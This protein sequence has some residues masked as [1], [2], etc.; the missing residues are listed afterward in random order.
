MQICE[1]RKRYGNVWH[2]RSQ[3]DENG[4]RVYFTEANAAQRAE[5]PE[6]PATTLTNFF[7]TCQTDSF[8]RTLFYSEMPLFYTWNAALEK[9]QRRKKREV[10]A[11]FTDVFCTDALIYTVHPRQDE[12]FYLR[13]IL[14]NI[15]GPKSF[16][17]LR[18]VDTVRYFSGGLPTFEST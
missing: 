5:S 4:Q 17:S 6:T 14:V 11:G 3:G 18:T 2:R 1:Q 15:R 8:A 10:F 16:E 13:L 7:S 9:F 12:C